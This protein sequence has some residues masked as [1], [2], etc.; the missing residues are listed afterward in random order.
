MNESISASKKKKETPKKKKTPKKKTPTMTTKTQENDYAVR[1]P[2][3]LATYMQNSI[4][5]SGLKRPPKNEKCFGIVDKCG[6]EIMCAA[7]Q[8]KTTTSN[9]EEFKTAH[10][11]EVN[12][13]VGRTECKMCPST[14]TPKMGGK[15]PGLLCFTECV[16]PNQTLDKGYSTKVGICSSCNKAYNELEKKRER[17]RREKRAEEKWPGKGFNNDAFSKKEANPLPTRRKPHPYYTADYTCAMCDRPFVAKNNTDVA[18]YEGDAVDTL[19][20]YLLNSNSKNPNR[21]YRL[22]VYKGIRCGISVL[23]ERN[24][25]DNGAQAPVCVCDDCCGRIGGTLAGAFKTHLRSNNG[26]QGLVE[27]AANSLQ[28]ETFDDFH[29]K[30]IEMQVGYAWKNVDESNELRAWDSSDFL[31]NY[32]GFPANEPVRLIFQFQRESPGSAIYSSQID[33][34]A[35]LVASLARLKYKDTGDLVLLVFPGSFRDDAPFKC[36]ICPDTYLRTGPM[37]GSLLARTQKSK[38]SV[39]RDVPGFKELLDSV[40]VALRGLHVKSEISILLNSPA[41]LTSSALNLFA[42]LRMIEEPARVHVVWKVSDAEEGVGGTV[43][44]SDLLYFL[45][46]RV[47]FDEF[48]KI[49]FRFDAV[50]RACQNATAAAKFF[51][52]IWQESTKGLRKT[53]TSEVD[54]QRQRK[55]KFDNFHT[56]HNYREMF[57]QP[58]GNGPPQEEQDIAEAGS[59]S[60]TDEIS[61]ATSKKT[62]T[63]LLSWRQAPI[64]RKPNDGGAEWFTINQLKSVK[65]RGEWHDKSDA[66]S[67]KKKR[68]SGN[69]SNLSSK[70][71]KSA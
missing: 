51:R 26:P 1:S 37:G 36:F 50:E 60:N 8:P 38:N 6:A 58:E 12:R 25:D 70:N 15:C 24:D 64:E 5:N 43:C 7:Y 69:F 68:T 48:Q 4:K 71:K 57:S 3:E 44:V 34:C 20:D 27:S 9:T 55:K 10:H 49:D 17:S 29:G 46:N 52:I 42:V 21:D 66:C 11:E 63:Y 14:E 62:H 47:N 59:Q 30:P 22:K 53:G 19:G 2:E 41:D 32:S 16:G 31:E 23:F 39:D 33:Y 35:D 67:P 45:R 61:L 18:K 28:D 40:N 13:L 65:R 56:E 54:T